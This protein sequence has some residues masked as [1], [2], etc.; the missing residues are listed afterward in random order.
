MKSI[1]ILFVRMKQ[2]KTPAPGI[3]K[4]AIHVETGEGGIVETV[5]NVLMD[6]PCH[7]NTAVVLE[8][9]L[10]NKS[11]PANSKKAPLLSTFWGG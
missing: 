9:H 7:V 6:Y 2:H 4:S 3:V 5:I 11:N 8:A 10:P 1:G